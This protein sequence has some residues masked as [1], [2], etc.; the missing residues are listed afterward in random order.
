MAIFSLAQLT[1]PLTRAEVEG[2]IYDVLAAVGTNTTSWKPGAVVRTMISA[3]SIILSAFS[4]LTALIARGGYLELASGPWLTLVAWYVYAVERQFATYAAGEV[5]LVNAGG[6]IFIL[7]A[8]DLVVANPDTGKQYRNVEAIS[9]G[10][11]GTLTV[12]VVALEAGS[13]S[14]SAPHTVVTFITPLLGVTVDNAVSIVGSDDEED[15]A[16]RARCSEKLG[17]LSPMGP[18]DAYSY[19][20]RNATRLDGAV[21]GVTRVRTVKDG[22]GNVTTYVATATGEVSGTVD[23]LDTDLGCVD[24]AIQKKAAP[25]AVNAWVVSA[26]PLAIAVSYRVWMYNTSGLTEA[27]IAETIALRLVEFMSGQPIG[28]NV[29]SADPG[30][31]FVDAIRTAIGSTFPQIFHVVVEVPAADVVLAINQVPTLG[32]VTPLA[33]TQV[34]PSEGSA[35]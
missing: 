2:K 32:T 33:I 20:A 4:E 26:T 9:L 8:G 11:L 30:K 29:V 25:L 28:G 1:T 12:A 16:L 35:P 17:S 31:V 7:D 5:T 6:G 18:W 27:E 34:P 15:P 23:D 13:S 19:A 24:D 22:F 3:C 14:T 21:I 10:A